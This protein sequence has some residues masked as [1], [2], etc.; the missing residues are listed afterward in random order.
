L[1][2]TPTPLALYEAPKRHLR[3][4]CPESALNLLSQTRTTT[5]SA[6]DI[7]PPPSQLAIATSSVNRLLKDV[8][9]YHKELA[10]QEGQVQA[11]EDKIKN[12]QNDEDG[13]ASFMLK[14]QV[15]QMLPGCGIYQ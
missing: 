13:N 8:A 3:G 6:A 1:S 10:E 7:M 9:S 12:G 15:R 2:S 14:Q 5:E 4:I 11:L